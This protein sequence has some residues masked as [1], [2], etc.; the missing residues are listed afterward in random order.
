MT[1]YHD[2]QLARL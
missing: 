1:L 2:V